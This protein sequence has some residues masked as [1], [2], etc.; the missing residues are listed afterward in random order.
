MRV[1]LVG[2]LGIGKST[3]CR[4]LEIIGFNCI[5][6]NL[7]TNPFLDD[8]FKNPADYRFPSQMWFALTKFY[9]IKKFEQ[10][11]LINVLDQALLNV[12]AYTKMLFRQ[13]DWEALHIFNQCFDYL[14]G[15]LG[16]PDLLIYL[17]CSPAE[18]IRRIRARDRDHEKG[19][20]IGYIV[21]LQHEINTLMAQARSESCQILTIDTEEVY[22]PDNLHYAEKLAR[23]ISELVYNKAK[24]AVRQKKIAA[25]DRSQLA[26]YVEMA[27]A[28]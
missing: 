8:C 1:E 24:P 11:E 16:S 14:E 7:K 13:E 25:N 23:L 10:P 5:Y 22:L 2:G 3:L 19:V 18:Q 12:R 27:E 21:D 26:H 15:Q 20:S 6:E 28:M 4:N 17:K 9:E